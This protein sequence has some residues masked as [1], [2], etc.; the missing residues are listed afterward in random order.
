MNVFVRVKPEQH[1]GLQELGKTAD[2][3]LRS[4]VRDLI[5][6]AGEQDGQ[7]LIDQGVNLPIWRND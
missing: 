1:K 7:T 5:V 4:L 2:K 6:W 3:S